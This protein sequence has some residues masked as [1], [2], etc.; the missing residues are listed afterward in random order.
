MNMQQLMMQAQ[1]MQRE[2]KKA[3]EALASTLFTKNRGGMVEVKMYGNFVV[4]SITIDEDAFDADNKDMVE[5]TIAICINELI[6]EI[7]DAEEE[8]NNKI[9]GSPHGGGLF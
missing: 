7:R 6:E 3:K 4:D 5:E 8:I 1:K 2:L 9:T